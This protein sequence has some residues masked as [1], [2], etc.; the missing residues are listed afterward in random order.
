[1]NDSPKSFEIVTGLGMT[2]MMRGQ[3]EKAIMHFDEALRIKPDNEFVTMFLNVSRAR[4]NIISQIPDMMKEVESW[5]K[6]VKKRLDLA[7]AFAY[8]NKI[9]EAEK[10]FDQLF[11]LNPTG[12]EIY[13]SIGVS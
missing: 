4:Q 3:F 13:L 2:Y 1:M 10:H 7:S 9:D 6:D 8:I 5:P 12:P 11:L